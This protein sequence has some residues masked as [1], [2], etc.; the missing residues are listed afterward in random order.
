MKS[1]LMMAV[2]AATLCGASWA[3]TVNVNAA[4]AKTISK[5]LV[6][7]GDSTATRIVEERSAHGPYK[8]ADDLA[9][10]VKGVGK[11]TLEKNQS[12]LKFGG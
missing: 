1:K 10:R 2:L 11:K 7:V 5:E 4:D 8:S 6:G 12:N 9:K 3:G